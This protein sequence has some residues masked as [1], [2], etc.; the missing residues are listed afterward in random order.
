[1]GRGKGFRRLLL[2]PC[3]DIRF[4]TDQ[5]DRS[6]ITWKHFGL[7]EIQNALSIGPQNCL[8]QLRSDLKGA[9]RMIGL[10][11]LVFVSQGD[12][13]RNGEV[14][15]LADSLLRKPGQDVNFADTDASE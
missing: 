5:S 10:G 9:G 4:G 8:Y 2:W 14:G 3:Q 12:D 13:V 7:C 1:M 11:W 6:G 15:I